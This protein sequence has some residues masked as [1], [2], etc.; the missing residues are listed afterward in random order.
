MRN[1]IC[2]VISFFVVWSAILS[3]SPARAGNCD[4]WS[5]PYATAVTIPFFLK[6]YDSTAVNDNE[7]VTLQSSATFASGDVKVNCDTAGDTNVATLPT[8]RGL[9]YSQPLS[10][11][12]TTCQRGTI[13]WKDQTSPS[14]WIDHCA[15][16]LTYNNSSAFHSTP[17]RA[18]VIQWNSNNVPVPDTAG[19]PIVTLKNG[20][21]SGEVVVASGKIG[22]V[23]VTDSVNGNVSGSVGSVVGNVGGTIN[24][25]TANAL[26][27]FFDTDSNTTF[28]SAVD[29]SVVSEVASNC[30]GGGGGGGGGGGECTSIAAGAIT[31]DSFASSVIGHQKTAQAV[32]LNDITLNA[33]EAW[34]SN[35]LAD[36]TAVLITGATGSAGYW[37]VRCIKSNSSLTKKAVFTEPLKILP[38]SPVKY[39]IIPAPNCNKSK[40]PQ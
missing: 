13:V 5:I 15:E 22:G 8:D 19:Y 25:L 26:K 38:G 2:F 39:A 18:N 33:S 12:E 32:T 16:F 17:S 1:I 34:G 29:G 31:A 20:T 3:P 36:N 11:A 35:V 28:A 9:G 4:Q 21:G 40:W 23:A 7:K 14:V 27:D 6:K 30:S 10:A 37:Q 24:G